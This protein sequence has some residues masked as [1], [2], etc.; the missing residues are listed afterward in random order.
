VWL[1]P[2]SGL[3]WPLLTAGL[4]ALSRGIGPLL[5]ATLGGPLSLWTLLVLPATLWS[6]LSSLRTLLT[7]SLRA[8]LVLSATLGRPLPLRALLIL[9]ATLGRPLPLRALLVLS[10]TLWRSLPLGSLLG[11]LARSAGLLLLFF[12]AGFIYPDP[13]RLFSRERSRS[14]LGTA[15][16]AGRSL[17]LRPLPVRGAGPYRSGLLS[18]GRWPPGIMGRPTSGRRLLFSAFRPLIG[19]CLSFVPFRLR[20]RLPGSLYPFNSTGDLSYLILFQ[21]THVVFHIYTYCR[22]AAD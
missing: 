14:V 1:H 3:T 11:P 2:L 13:L 9:P 22:K 18:A 21:R 16:P 6:W 7:C 10:A 20:R 4:R 8:L 19:N 17:S 15:F 12:L 5:T